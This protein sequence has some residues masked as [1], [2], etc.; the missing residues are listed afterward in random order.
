M[1]SQSMVWLFIVFFMSFVTVK[2]FMLIYSKVSV[3][4]LRACDFYVLFK[5][6]FPSKCHENSILSSPMKVLEFCFLHLDLQLIWNLSFC[7]V[8]GE[9]LNLFI[10]IAN[11]S[12]FIYC[13]SNPS[14]PL[15]VSN[16]KYIL[17]IL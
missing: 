17:S 9:Y 5:Q 10:Y 7:M 12:R 13:L 16:F 4:S 14:S 3:F 1:Y 15:L 8:W 11:S 2:I 6:F